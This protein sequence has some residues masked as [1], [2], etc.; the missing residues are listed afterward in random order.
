[1][2]CALSIL[3]LE[4]FVRP[5]EIILKIVL[6][7]CLGILGLQ[8]A[9]THFDQLEYTNGFYCL[10][11]SDL[12]FSGNVVV[13]N[14]NLLRG[15]G[16]IEEGLFQGV[17]KYYHPDGSIYATGLY[18]DGDGLSE[19]YVSGIPRN[20]REGV[21]TFYYP[22]GNKSTEYTYV[23]RIQSGVQKEWYENGQIRRR[24]NLDTGD[25]TLWFANGQKRY[26]G[27]E[28]TKDFKEWYQNGKLRKERN[29]K[30]GLT[31][32]YYS[33]GQKKNEGQL[34]DEKRHGPWFFWDQS[35]TLTEKLVYEQGVRVGQLT[36]TMSETSGDI[37]DI[38]EVVRYHNNKKIRERGY[39]TTAGLQH[40]LWHT[41]YENGN[42]QSEGVYDNGQMSGE[43]K[44]WYENSQ[45]RIHQF[46]WEGKP[47]G[48]YRRYDA[49]G[50][51]LE[52]GLYSHGKKEGLWT[53]Y[54]PKGESQS[55]HYRDDK[56]NGRWTY[57]YTDGVELSIW[58]NHGEATGEWS[59][60][61]NLEDK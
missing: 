14:G 18:L 30:D 16:R 45:I 47:H 22:N 31:R 48:T 11:G 17:W 53:Y 46:F 28:K 55:G 2:R 61:V 59:E 44:F 5:G 41:Y 42:K 27:N 1:M 29:S 10:K 4:D 21:W 20:G 38:F 51:L 24:E 39:Q 35:G 9:E 8:A 32:E 33:N 60:K 13:M 12:P 54:L 40:G 7:L 50:V 34:I 37:E 6:M 58:F 36:P 19:S 26:E 3:P 57:S 52:M 15:K 56:K 49:S 23:N 25:L 43:W